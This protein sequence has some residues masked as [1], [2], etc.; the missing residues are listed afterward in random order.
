MARPRK[1]FR[2]ITVS[3]TIPPKIHK[4][5]E[6]IV[7]K[8]YY[9]SISEFIRHAIYMQLWRDMKMMEFYEKKILETS[10]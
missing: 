4:N 7:N 9:P 6:K 10:I 1:K 8:G 3:V 2:V 5:I